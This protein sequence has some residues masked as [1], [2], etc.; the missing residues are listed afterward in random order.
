MEGAAILGKWSAANVLLPDIGEP[1]TISLDLS[2]VCQCY[3]AFMH[4]HWTFQVVV[5]LN[6]HLTAG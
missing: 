3:N 2:F 1:A 6:K 5:F 4:R